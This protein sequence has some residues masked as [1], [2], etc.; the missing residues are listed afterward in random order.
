MYGGQN[1]EVQV[2]S[3]FS[4]HKNLKYFMTRRK[5]T[6]RQSRWAEFLSE[7]NFTLLF[8]PG[9]E[10]PV[11]DAL[12]RRDQDKPHGEGDEREQGRHLQLIPSSAIPKVQAVTNAGSEELPEMAVFEDNQELQEL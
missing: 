2:P 12:S 7:F 6:E 8:R 4:D 5:L 11:P 1:S 10:S 9:S 3:V